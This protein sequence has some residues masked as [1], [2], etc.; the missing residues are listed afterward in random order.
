MRRHIPG[1]RLILA[2]AVTGAVVVAGL[3]GLATASAQNTEPSGRAWHSLVADGFGAVWLFGGD[4]AN[5]RS[6][7]LWWL[8]V[9]TETWSAM[10]PK[11]KKN[12]AARFAHAT[13]FDTVNDLLVIFG[14]LVRI[15]HSDNVVGDTWIYTPNTNRWSS[16]TGC[17][18]SDDSGGSGKGGGKGGGGKGGGKS[19]ANAAKGP[20]PR[21]QA[22]MAFNAITGEATLFGG[23]DL[24]EGILFGDTWTLQIVDGEACWSSEAPTG[25][26]P[27]P[28]AQ[29][30]MAYVESRRTLV[31]YGG[32]IGI[33]NPPAEN[34][35]DLWEWDGVAWSEI[36]P[37]NP[38]DAPCLREAN[39][40]YDTI[41]DELIVTGGQSDPVGDWQPNDSVYFYSFAFDQWSRSDG[42][43]PFPLRA[44]N[45][46]AHSVDP[47]RDT[48]SLAHFGGTDGNLYLG[49]TLIVPLADLP[50][51]DLG[52]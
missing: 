47:D 17:P 18:G 14:G 46:I 26:T 21:V 43:S 3:Q 30:A 37:V 1:N 5:G 27:D 42:R 16:A 44:G 35:C 51:A 41:T 49:D 38:N 13:T 39:L 19:G 20:P 36:V 29:A 23:H 4:T 31:M 15:Q 40:A 2:A 33:N 7:E 24:F 28:V 8:D 9:F 52:L 32:L 34:R 25:A 22:A 48:D 10:S 45:P 11:S 50:L 12:P 6:D